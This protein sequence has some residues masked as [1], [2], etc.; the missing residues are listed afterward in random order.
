MRKSSVALLSVISNGTLVILKLIVGVLVGSVSVISEA[1]HSGFD[2]LAAIIAFLSVRTSAK[3][4]DDEHPFG[5]GKYENVSAAVEA[6]LIF[7]AA[8]WIIREAVHKLIRPE[9]L[10]M[11]GWGVAVMFFSSLV[12]VAVS[13]MLMKVGKQTDS[14]ALKADAW[15]LLTDVYTSAGVMSA[16]LIIWI[17]NWIFPKLNLQWIDPIAAILVALLIIKAAWD[18][19]RESVR[20]LLDVRLSTGEETWIREYLKS[21]KTLIRGFHGLRT[22]RPSDRV[23]SSFTCCLI[24]TCRLPNPTGSVIS[25]KQLSWTNFQ[26]PSSPFMSSRATAPASPP[27]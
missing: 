7:V 23:T 8:W 27:A 1:I 10:E 13:R 4:A 5:H 18:L 25:S 9:P 6:L 21:M 11:I 16:L 14:V 12:N 15:H 3:P 22:G 2:L 20:D 19:T 26:G 17:G 24:P